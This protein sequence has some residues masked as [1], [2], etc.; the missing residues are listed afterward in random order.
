MSSSQEITFS[1]LL[2]EA[3]KENCDIPSFYNALLNSDELD[4]IENDNNYVNEFELL[5]K[6]IRKITKNYVE[7][8]KNYTN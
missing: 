6:I 7:I 4:D 1:N 3:R 8:S 5:N 2:E